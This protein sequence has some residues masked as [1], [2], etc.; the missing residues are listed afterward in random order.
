MLD[1]MNTDLFSKQSFLLHF[2][3]KIILKTPYK[4]QFVAECREIPERVW[5]GEPNNHNEFPTSS[6]TYVINLCERWG[7]S[8]PDDIRNLPPS[9]SLEYHPR[10]VTKEL[11]KLLIKFLYNPDV[12]NDLKEKLPA[13]R[14]VPS[15]KTWEISTEFSDAVVRFATKWDFHFDAGISEEIDL[16]MEK[17]QAAYE[18]SHAV[19]GDIH[20]DGV[21]DD[22]LPYQKI[23]ISYLRS[24]RRAILGDQPGLG[25]TLQALSTLVA[26]NAFPAVVVCPN[27]LK[28]NWRNEIRKFYPHLTVNVVSGKSSEALPEADITIINYDIVYERVDDLLALNPVALV[29]DES[30]AIKNGKAIHTCSGCG[31]K[32][33]SNAK[34]CGACKAT[35]ITPVRGWTVKRAGGVLRLAESIPKDGF[36]L[37]LTG[38]P[39]TNRPIELVPQLEAIGALD[40]FGGRWKFESRYCPNGK[41]AAFMEELNRKMRSTCYIRRKKQDVYGELPDVRNAAQIL[42]I[43][44][45]AYKRYHKIEQDVV[46]FLAEKAREFA[47][48][49][50]QDPDAAYFQKMRQLEFN[51]HLVKL[52]VLRDAVSQMKYDAITDWL[53]EFLSDGEEKVVVFAEHIDFVENLC[54]RYGDLAV[55][56]RGGVSN[57][58]RMAAVDRFQN[59]PSC[60]LFIANMKA[61]SEGL[62]LTAASDVVFCELGWTPAIHEQCVGRCYGRVNDLHGA[63]AWYLL[64]ERTIDEDIYELLEEKKKV[65]DAVTDGE[66]PVVGGSVILDLLTRLTE[67]GLRG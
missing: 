32:V 25:K 18:L 56:V 33:R 39:I 52:T 46:G 28:L 27:T 31:A 35:D 51:E 6:V 59:D 7:I 2:G 30:H 4:K 37:L 61:A 67:R 1:A 19:D 12:L 64:A 63:T 66:D 9:E 53:D 58:D 8:V 45:A 42:N 40:H 29:A 14:W 57:D 54:A 65:V 62:T 26:E 47:K 3:D 21:V 44:D 5:V 49:N 24:A 17:R 34:N 60:R 50:G 10:T 20:I 13:A 11:D 38:T 22:L 16:L 36:V 48:E 55:K 41:G 43:S 15:S 23:G